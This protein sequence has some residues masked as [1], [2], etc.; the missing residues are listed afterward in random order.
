MSCVPQ[1]QGSTDASVAL[2]EGA[3]DCHIH[4][5]DAV[6]APGA[7][8]AA[9]LSLQ[10]RLGL[11]RGVLVQPSAYGT[12]NSL[13]LAALHAL[14]R[15]RFRLVAV[16]DPA[17]PDAE[18]AH[19]D[20]EGMRGV[21]FNL[22]LGGPLRVDHLLPMARRI[23]PLGWHCQ[24]NMAPEQLVEEAGLLRRLPCRLVIDHL[25]QVPQ[26]D[27]LRSAAFAVLRDLLA[28]G[29]SWVK[30][31]GPYITSRR[32]PHDY[33]DAGEVAAALALVAPDRV[34][35]GSDW[36]HPS[37]PAS[38]KPDDRTLLDLLGA[39]VPDAAAR[40]RVLVD[41]PAELYGFDA[42]I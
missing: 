38:A 35:W 16:L 8:V 2:P 26:P 40:R 3:T 15:E 20:A 22:K 37:E 14:G 39:W 21:R 27:G 12:D 19:L 4:V 36:P 30:L 18:L 5:Y 25:G 6:R 33:A 31:S 17:A 24:V 28:A 13:H 42:A 32:G 23:A 29:N 7:D 1:V 9:Y 10:C 34:L 11:S 41:N